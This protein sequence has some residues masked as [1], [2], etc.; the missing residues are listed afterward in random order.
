MGKFEVEVLYRMTL[1][2]T[3]ILPPWVIYDQIFPWE[4]ERSWAKY[5]LG[6][7]RRGEPKS[8]QLAFYVETGK[9][10]E[11]EGLTPDAERP[12]VDWGCLERRKSFD[13]VAEE[14]K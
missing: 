1:I 2:N 11:L 13:E 14:E 6:H 9:E 10:G 12:G 4:Y 7:T 3:L 5:A 8:Q